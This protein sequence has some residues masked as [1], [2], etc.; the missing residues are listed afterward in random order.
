VQEPPNKI[1]SPKP[2]SHVRLISLSSCGS[3]SLMV[4]Q[5]VTDIS[6]AP[7]TKACALIYPT[8]IFKD[9]PSTQK[10][11]SE[12]LVTKSG[13]LSAQ[14]HCN[15]P[16]P[17]MITGFNPFVSVEPTKTSV[18][19][20]LCQSASFNHRNG[21]LWSRPVRI[22]LGNLMERGRYW[23]QGSHQQPHSYYPQ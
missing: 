2:D 5:V 17:P 12:T 4:G 14:D 9:H 23:I 7:I 22:N 1:E 16:R 15:N 3:R 13:G 20:G 6:S 10:L 19:R 8:A 21:T 18:Y 11:V